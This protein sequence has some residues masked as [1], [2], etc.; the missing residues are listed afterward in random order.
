MPAK[1]P[2]EI[3]FERHETRHASFIR[4]AD[5]GCTVDVGE[6]YVYEVW[7]SVGDEDL[8]QLLTCEPCKVDY[9]GSGGWLRGYSR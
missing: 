3:A 7:K 1:L 2:G 9:G 4:V 8:S 6:P 5:C